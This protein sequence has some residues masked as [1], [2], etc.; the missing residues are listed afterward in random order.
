MNRG[1]AATLDA[2]GTVEIGAKL[3]AT[4]APV[5][6][7]GAGKFCEVLDINATVAFKKAN[8]WVLG[9]DSRTS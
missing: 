1:I 5:I 4:V 7:V 8:S 6:A 3:T 9:L 2:I